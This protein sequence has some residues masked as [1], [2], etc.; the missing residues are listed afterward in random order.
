VQANFVKF[1]FIADM[2]YI[3]HMPK[4]NCPFCDSRAVRVT[5]VHGHKFYCSRCG[6]NHEIVQAELSSTIKLS[7][8]LFTLGL[9][10]A[11]GAGV[12]YP[13]E[14]W[15]RGE[16]LGFS[17]LPL[18]YALFAL[19]QIRKLR[20]FSFQPAP[21]QVGTITIPE[22]SSSVGDAS[23]TITFRKKEFPELTALPRPRK[24]KITWRGRGYLA[25][26]SIVIALYTTYGL[27]EVWS[28]FNSP[29]SQRGGYWVLLLPA[30]IYGYSFAFFRKRFRERQLLANG[31]LASGYVTAQQNG[32]YGQ[33]IN[34][35]FILPGGETINGQCNDA[36]RSLYE[37]MTVPVFYDADNP[38]RSVPLPCSLTKVVVP[39][40]I[41]L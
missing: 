14:Q 2:Y 10:V 3:S 15:L 24:L 25:F 11:I 18:F 28:E 19:L 35:C 20:S 23:T 12:K 36:S 7:L 34:Y 22:T 33:S 39:K 40:P 31:E 41:Q 26:A 4:V 32:R 21:H 16:I 38:K 6:W 37:G 13:S 1:P 5:L 9:L 17:A 29:H 27:P 30:M 8:V